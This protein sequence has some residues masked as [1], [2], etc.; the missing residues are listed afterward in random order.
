MKCNL[1]AVGLFLFFLYYT[2]ESMVLIV[3]GNSEIDAH[4]GSNLCYL[5]CLRH[6]IRSKAVTNRIFLFE[7]TYF[8]ACAACIELPSNISTMVESVEYT[9]GQKVIK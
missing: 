3:D 8:H 4:V 6:S 9:M 7:K 1:F 5:I 2:V